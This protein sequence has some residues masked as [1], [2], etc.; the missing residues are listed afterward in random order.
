MPTFRTTDDVTLAY[1]DE[2]EGRPVVL[3]HGYTAPATVVG[4]HRRRPSRCRAT[5]R[6]P[7]TG[8]RTGSPRPRRTASGWR[9]TA[10]T[11]ASSWP[12]STSRDAVVVGASMGGNTLWAYVDQFG[13]ARL[14]GAVI[15]DQ[16]PKML[17]AH[18]WEHGF[19]GYEATNAGTLFA[20]GVPVPGGGR[21]VDRSG[22]AVLRLVERLGAP[23][24]FRDPTAPETLPLLADHALQ[25]WRDVVRRFPLPLLMLAGR[26]SQIWPCAHAEAAVAGS[27]RGRALVIEDAGHAISFDQPDRF[28][29][30]LL[31]FLA[32][33]DA[34]PPRTDPTGHEAAGTR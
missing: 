17:N 8:A 21:T 6:S 33:V 7:S 18:G 15:V 25:D 13:P 27:P 19:Y 12:T 31:D 32:E 3:V 4:A 26:E 10:A 9:A 22:P 23:P 5:G 34:E 20:K 1:T 28:N 2:G 11:S 14:A 29:E 24:A 16:T 30:V